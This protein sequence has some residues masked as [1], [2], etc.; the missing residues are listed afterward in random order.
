MS[1]VSLTA[2]F[3][4]TIDGDEVTDGSLT[5]PISH[6]IG[7]AG[8]EIIYDKI[9]SIAASGGTAK[10]FDV[11]DNQNLTDFEFLW[12]VP[13]VDVLI[14]LNVDDNNG[15]G[16]RFFTFR[17]KANVPFIMSSNVAFANSSD[18]FGGTSDFLERINVKND[19][20][21]AAKVRVIALS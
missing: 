10:V 17:A 7:T 5:T 8:S 13:S 20:S 21:S 3:T 16:E 14:Q 9:F 18:S 15:V 19:G 6:S 12:I 1:T 2:H 4:T 11:A